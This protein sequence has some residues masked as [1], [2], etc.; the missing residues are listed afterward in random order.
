MGRRNAEGGMRNAERIVPDKDL[1]ERTKKLALQIIKLVAS[2]P[3]TREADLIGRQ[4]L[5]AGTSVGANYREARTA[6]A[7]Q[8]SNRADYCRRPCNY[9]VKS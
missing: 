6:I 5:K 9:E 3:R 8:R 7:P 2:L 1:K 4:L